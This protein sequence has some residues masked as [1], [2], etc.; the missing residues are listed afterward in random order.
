[1]IV[2]TGPGA[3]DSSVLTLE[4]TYVKHRSLLFRALAR[5]T[6]EG[7]AVPPDEG[8]DLIH[9]FF[10]DSWDGI[11]G[12]FDPGQGPLAPYLYTAFVQYA[13]PRIVRLGRLKRSLV[14]LNELSNT[15]VAPG[16]PADE[17]LYADNLMQSVA[18]GLE[19]IER[20]DRLI[21][22]LF[23]VEGLSERSLARTF[24]LSR[25]AL[26]ERLVDA[27]GR[28]AVNVRDAAHEP[29]DDWRVAVAIWGKRLTTEEC[30]ASI[31]LTRHQV[32]VAHRRNHARLAAALAAPR[33]Q[34]Q[35]ASRPR[36]A[37]PLT[38]SISGSLKE[39]SMSGPH[40]KPIPVARLIRD[41]VANPNDET[42]RAHVKNRDQEVYAWLATAEARDTF[43]AIEDEAT[44]TTIYDALGVKPC[45]KQLPVSDSLWKAYSEDRA[46]IGKAFREVLVPSLPGGVDFIMRHFQ[47]LPAVPDALE[48][49][50]LK[51]A[52]VENGETEAIPLVR[53]GVTP[54]VLLHTTT[55]IADVLDRATETGLVSR[56]RSYTFLNNELLA[57][58]E[59]VV[60]S[61]HF[62]E[63]I[64]GVC[65][66]TNEFA[67]A[68]LSWATAAAYHVPFIFDGYRADPALDQRV[69]IFP[70]GTTE[71]DLFRRWR[72][73]AC[74]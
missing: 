56:D 57:G 1:M 55:A 21:L 73:A 53:F 50:L 28:L 66:S 67:S 15:W 68:C 13:R 27:L 45:D 48:K 58:D 43:E 19:R 44:A 70:T 30:A 18:H 36:T 74:V 22:D 46:Q 32:K 72:T 5:L 34:I 12:R 14:D 20:D 26:R 42:L 25:Y 33:R 4:Q 35:Q 71:G 62:I 69:R 8:L 23:F 3:E 40:L 47:T 59:V 16:P 41:L 29:D 49:E 9:A 31:G 38:A 7:F 17:L 61:G 37:A 60:Q 2:Q 52:D 64:S 6:A 10:V 51:D 11:R 24:D 39:R 54:V 65:D 63:E